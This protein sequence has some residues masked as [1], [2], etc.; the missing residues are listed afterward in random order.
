MNLRGPHPDLD[1]HLLQETREIQERAIAE[2]RDTA[3]KM[4]T[5]IDELESLGKDSLQWLR[6]IGWGAAIVYVAGLIALFVGRVISRKSIAPMKPFVT[7]VLDTL[8]EI[9]YLLNVGP[10]GKPNT[11]MQAMETAMSETRLTDFGH[12]GQ[13]QTSRSDSL[14][15]VNRYETSQSSGLGKCKGRY[16]PLGYLLSFNTLKGINN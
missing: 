1:C 10:W 16:S 3:L 5:I 6:H 14:G 9:P 4:D 15:F 2:S 8:L 7:V 11:I 12:D 13:P